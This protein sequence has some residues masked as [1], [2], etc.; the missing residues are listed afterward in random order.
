[1]PTPKSCDLFKGVFNKF[2][3]YYLFSRAHEIF[4]WFLKNS[5]SRFRYFIYSTKVFS[6]QVNEMALSL[7]Y[8]KSEKPF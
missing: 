5:Q 8:C 4:F 2:H 1:M 6:M 7:V 3:T